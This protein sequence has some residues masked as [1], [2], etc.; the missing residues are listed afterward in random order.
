MA[1]NENIVEQIKIHFG[2]FSGNTI[3]YIKDMDNVS[4]LEED[5]LMFIEDNEEVN[6]FSYENGLLSISLK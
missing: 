4:N 1:L 5:L 6:S 2:I 3:L